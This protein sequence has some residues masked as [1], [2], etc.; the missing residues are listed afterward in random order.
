MVAGL[1]GAFVFLSTFYT[2]YVQCFTERTAAMA[3]S[4]L[5]GHG[6]RSQSSCLGA[7][8]DGVD[9]LGPCTQVHG[10]GQLL[11]T[12][13]HNLLHVCSD[14]EKHIVVSVTSGPPTTRLN[15]VARCFW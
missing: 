11:D 9:F 10:G 12:W 1:K 2:P 13:P 5:C 15:Q 4:T 7:E 6:L 14:M 3:C 8:V